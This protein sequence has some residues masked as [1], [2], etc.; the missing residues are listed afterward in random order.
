M[1]NSLSGL[2]DGITQVDQKNKNPS[3]RQGKQAVSQPMWKTGD[4]RAGA[5][6][7]IDS[8]IRGACRPGTQHLP[9]ERVP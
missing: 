2:Q 3:I 5:S 9:V 6:V 1:R 7:L 4:L 8:A